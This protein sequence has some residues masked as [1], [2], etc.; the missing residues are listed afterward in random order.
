MNTLPY[1]K[2]SK[3]SI[4]EFGL[5]LKWTTFRDVLENYINISTNEPLSNEDKAIL[6]EYYNRIRSKGGLGNLIEEY[7]FHLPPDHHNA[8]KPDF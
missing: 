6:Y 8:S 7:H 2:T 1:D 4:E 3:K 5:K